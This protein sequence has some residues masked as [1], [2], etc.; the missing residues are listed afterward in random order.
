MPVTAGVDAT[1]YVR[2]LF[3]INWHG[4]Q[5]YNVTPAPIVTGSVFM[6]IFRLFLIGKTILVIQKAASTI[7]NTLGSYEDKFRFSDC[8]RRV[9]SI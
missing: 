4:N 5:T 1:V 7:V 8:F 2:F 3:T 6:Q 9:L